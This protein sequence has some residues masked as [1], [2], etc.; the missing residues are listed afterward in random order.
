MLIS[1]STWTNSAVQVVINSF[2]GSPR[3]C[4]ATAPE[5]CGDPV[6]KSK[7]KKPRTS[8]KAV[9]KK[10]VVRPKKKNNSAKP[11][12]K[13]RNRSVK[14]EDA[15]RA[16]SRAGAV[17]LLPPVRPRGPKSSPDAKVTVASATTSDRD[18]AGADDLRLIMRL[19]KAE[20][21]ACPT[22]TGKDAPASH[23]HKI[24]DGVAEQEDRLE[25]IA[26]SLADADEDELLQA[27]LWWV[28]RARLP[29]AAIVGR[30][31]HDLKSFTEELASKRGTAD[32]ICREIRKRNSLHLRAEI[33]E[34]LDSTKNAEDVD[35][36]LAGLINSA[37]A[38]LEKLKLL[39]AAPRAGV[40][41]IGRGQ[42]VFK[43]FPNWN[44]ADEPWPEKPT[45]PPRRPRS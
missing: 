13:K 27:A 11:P 33:L 6:A 1:R 4:F 9:K 37:W 30:A 43:N 23:A 7:K 17:T 34:K 16:A 36:A 28:G 41:L 25:Q 5:G 3:S 44:K 42:K 26:P 24:A 35:S 22:Q 20:G 8:K 15:A 14:S 2:N 12:T 29:R 40:Y 10:P 38:V 45:R 18:I 31:L 39:R 32:T 21:E 19:D